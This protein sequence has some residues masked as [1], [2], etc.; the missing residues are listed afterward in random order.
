MVSEGGLETMP[1]AHLT[2]HQSG[3]RPMSEG[4]L[5]VIPSARWEPPIF[6]Y[7]LLNRCVPC[8]SLAAGRD[9]QPARED[10]QSNL[11]PHNSRH[12]PGQCTGTL[13]R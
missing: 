9:S 13:L 5:R 3:G 8:P 12:Q 1:C 2:P 6:G 10:E 7:R 4:E 11:E